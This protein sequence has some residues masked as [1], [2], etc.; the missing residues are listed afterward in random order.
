MR[1]FGVPVFPSALYLCQLFGR[2]ERGQNL[3]FCQ[4]MALKSQNL[5]L[6]MGL[7]TD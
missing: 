2:D 7:Q 5:H 1:F 3:L 4:F 6:D